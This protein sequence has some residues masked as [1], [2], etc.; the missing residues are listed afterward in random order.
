MQIWGNKKSI[1]DRQKSINFNSSFSSTTKYVVIGANNNGCENS[2]SI[3]VVVN[4]GNDG[5]ILP[6]S[7]SPNNDGLND[8]FG[9]KYYRDVN[10][11]AF[12]IFDRYGKIVFE[13]INAAECWN[14]N[15]MGQKADPGNYV[16]YISGNTSC[17]TVVK[18]GSLILIR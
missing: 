10:N 4:F 8:C 16:Y 1:S 9:I 2:D 3:T 18:K 15:F 6:N 12:I 17:G 7:F 11:L 5:I 13:T 14:G